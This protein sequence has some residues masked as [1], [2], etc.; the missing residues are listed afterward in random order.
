MLTRLRPGVWPGRRVV[1]PRRCLSTLRRPSCLCL[2]IS[3]RR[4]LGAAA[5]AASCRGC[6]TERSFGLAT[7]PAARPAPTP[8][9][10]DA[11]G[12]GLA[13][14]PGRPGR[15]MGLAPCLPGLCPA[16][17]GRAAGAGRG[18]A[19]PGLSP[20]PRGPAAAPPTEA[21]RGAGWG[22]PG[23]AGLPGRPGPAWVNT[24]GWCSASDP[25]HDDDASDAGVVPASSPSSADADSELCPSATGDKTPWRKPGPGGLADA[26]AGALA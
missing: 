21:C 26:A 9:E 16:V 10:P 25:P 4:V 11:K 17:A 15:A 5:G 1:V 8:P 13:G 3:S 20:G 24:A 18:R 23:R 2:R 14:R 7:M 6:A 19:G 12:A 22:L